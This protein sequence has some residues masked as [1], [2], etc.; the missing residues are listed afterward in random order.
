MTKKEKILKILSN[1]IIWLNIILNIILIIK[2]YPVYNEIYNDAYL[3]GIMYEISS[4]RYICFGGYC[5]LI[6]LFVLDDINRIRDE[7]KLGS[8]IFQIV[9]L[10]ILFVFKPIFSFFGKV[11]SYAICLGFTPLG[12]AIGLWYPERKYASVL[13]TLLSI[14][15]VILGLVATIVLGTLVVA[16]IHKNIFCFVYMSEEAEEKA[17]ARKGKENNC[18]HIAEVFIEAWEKEEQKQN[19]KRIGDELEKIRYDLSRK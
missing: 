11:Q 7:K 12:A 6:I 4:M 10:S 13:G 8:G 17:I 2:I 1:I 9:F 14:G 5:L 18:G 19:I 3:E 16:L 15:L